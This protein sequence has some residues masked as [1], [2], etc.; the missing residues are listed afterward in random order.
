MLGTFG[1]APSCVVMR[2]EIY[3]QCGGCR[4]ELSR[5]Q[6]TFLFLMAREHGP[7]HFVPESLARYQFVLP[8]SKEQRWL[9]ASATFDRLVLERFGVLP[10]V[11]FDSFINI[12][13]VHMARGE[14]A[15]ARERFLKALR[16]RPFEARTYLRLAWTCLPVGLSRALGASMPLPLRRELNGP[17]LGIWQCIAL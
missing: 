17:P 11:E 15:L 6:D 8:R 10:G 2:R 3:Q 12:G 14:R 7:F 16:L 4:E 13:L 9:E 5:H 1:I